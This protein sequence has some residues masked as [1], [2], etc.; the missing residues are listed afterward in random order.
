MI[1]GLNTLFSSMK[2]WPGLLTTS[3]LTLEQTS[4]LKISELYTISPNRDEPFQSLTTVNNS[5]L[6][7]ERNRRHL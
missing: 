5:S 4:N 3:D 6:L 7:R 2:T 1:Q